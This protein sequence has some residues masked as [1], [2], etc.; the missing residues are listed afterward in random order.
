MFH[1]TF[2]IIIIIIIKHTIFQ[3]HIFKPTKW[4]NITEFYVIETFPMISYNYTIDNVNN[5]KKS[6]AI[7]ER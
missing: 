7:K 1:K 5:S 4:R 6:T 3:I 2:E